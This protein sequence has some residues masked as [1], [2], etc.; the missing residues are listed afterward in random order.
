M[1]F[2]PT[3]LIKN[4][5]RKQRWCLLT[6]SVKIEGH[7]SIRS[8]RKIVVHCEFLWKRVRINKI[9]LLAQP[10]PYIKYIP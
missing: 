7:E 4:S 10:V 1:L 8:N 3:H 6:M 9:M 5:A 2:Y